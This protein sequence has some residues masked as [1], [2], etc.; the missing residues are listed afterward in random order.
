[1][2]SVEKS[3]IWFAVHEDGISILDY[4]SMVSGISFLIMVKV[5]FNIEYMERFTTT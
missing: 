1:M 4:S 2:S 5:D 3:F